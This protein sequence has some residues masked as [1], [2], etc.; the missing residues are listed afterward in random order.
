MAF[1]RRIV[2]SG[3]VAARLVKGSALNLPGDDQASHHH[4]RLLLAAALIGACGPAAAQPAGGSLMPCPP[5]AE[6][7]PSEE[8]HCACWA[9][10]QAPVWGTEVYSAASSICMAAVHAGLIPLSGGSVRVFA[11][12][13][14][15]RYAGSTRNGVTSEPSGAAPRSF[16][17]ARDSLRYGVPPDR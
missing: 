4:W 17:L 2:L 15:A 9:P 8:G 10:A 7:W 5:T 12:P 3:A 6:A 16:R 11:A 1:G 14:Q 13:G